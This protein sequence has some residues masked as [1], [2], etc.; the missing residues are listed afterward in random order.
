MIPQ[1]VKNHAKRAPVKA[2]AASRNETPESQM[3]S[4]TTQEELQAATNA[5]LRAYATS[6]EAKALVVKLA[7]MVDE[8][9]HAVGLQNSG[10]G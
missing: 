2:T 3:K 1:L 10:A 8:H 9:A 6:D 4:K 5:T 7:A